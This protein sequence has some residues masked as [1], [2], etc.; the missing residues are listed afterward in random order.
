MKS[1][2]YIT[3]K[4]ILRA[5]NRN[6]KSPSELRDHIM[7]ISLFISK[8]RSINLTQILFSNFIFMHAHIYFKN[9]FSSS[10]HI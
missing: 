9:N 8:L 3:E 6:F 2:L 10:L 4:Y 7:S 5:F 1:L